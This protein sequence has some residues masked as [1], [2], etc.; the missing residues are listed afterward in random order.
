MMRLETTY[1]VARRYNRV[2]SDL[3]RER[4]S[5]VYL[6][7]AP[8]VERLEV[9]LIVLGKNLSRRGVVFDIG[10]NLDPRIHIA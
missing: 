4:M 8:A 7:S 1:Q 5:P 9:R 10:F 2:R 3:L 6:P